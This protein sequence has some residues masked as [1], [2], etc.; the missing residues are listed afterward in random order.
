MWLKDQ[1]AVGG[2]DRGED[3]PDRSM[4]AVARKVLVDVQEQRLLQ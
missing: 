1:E 4:T 2:R 3:E